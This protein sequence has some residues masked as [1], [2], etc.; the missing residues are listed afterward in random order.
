MSETPQDRSLSSDYW[1]GRIDTQLEHISIRMKRMEVTTEQVR[2]VL[3]T[4]LDHM[5]I[6]MERRA[7]TLYAIIGGIA[8]L[9]ALAQLL[10]PAFMKLWMK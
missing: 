7:K 4:R 8:V 1:R 10:L 9:Y 3:E 5:H 2:T 6:C